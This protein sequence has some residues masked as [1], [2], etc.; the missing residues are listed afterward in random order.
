MIKSLYNQTNVSL[1]FYFIIIAGFIA[2]F[3]VIMYNTFD[4]SNYV[5]HSECRTSLDGYTM[6]QGVNYKKAVSIS[7]SPSIK[8]LVDAINFCNSHKTC[9]R[10][11]YNENS[12]NDKM[13]I[14]ED[15]TDTDISYS[16]PYIHTFTNN[17]VIKKKT[18]STS[19]STVTSSGYGGVDTGGGGDS[20]GE[21]G[22]GVDTGGGGGGGG[23]Y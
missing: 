10:F 1:V 16:D 8:N 14:V 6:D 13:K 7:N 22:G 12:L 23:G 20:G 17:N 19:S 9:Q 4:K 3:T 15:L 5:H 11:T 21:G 18:T 2:A